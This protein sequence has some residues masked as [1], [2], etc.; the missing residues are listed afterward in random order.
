MA[1]GPGDVGKQLIPPESGPEFDRSPEQTQKLLVYICNLRTPRTRWEEDKRIT[2]S[3]CP[4]SLT[5]SNKKASLKQ[6]G[7]HHT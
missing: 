3:S 4:A 2:E 5:C 6:G 7:R 1:V